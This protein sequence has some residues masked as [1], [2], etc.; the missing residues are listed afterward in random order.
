MKALQSM[1]GYWIEALCVFGPPV[2]SALVLAALV[3]RLILHVPG[4][5]K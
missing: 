1:K 5:C 2:L 4:G 3:A